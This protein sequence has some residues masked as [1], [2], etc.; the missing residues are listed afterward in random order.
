[1][2]KYF[3]AFFLVVAAKAVGQQTTTA[4]KIKE[5][6]NS[7]MQ[8][9]PVKGFAGWNILDRMKYYKVPGLSIAVISNYKVDWAKAYGMADTTLHTPVTTETM[10]SA[11]SISKLLMAVTALKLV[12]T[13]KI[14]LDSPINNY[15]TSWK[16]AGN[17]FTQKTPVTLRMLLSH[18][19]GTSQSSYFGFT[20]DK[21]PL[22]TIVQIL[23]GD[24]VAATRRVVV[25]SEPNKVF[26]YSGG[27]SMIA[28]MAL[29]DVS[30]Q[31]FD[32]LTKQ[33]LFDKLGMKHST[34]A[35]PVP[36]A[37]AGK[38]AWG[39]SAASWYKGMPYVYPQ[40]AAAGLYTTPTDLA[41]FFIDIQLSVLGKG[42]VL[43]KGMA[44]EMLTP[45]VD[46]SDGGYKEQMGVGPFLL[47]RTDNR[48]TAGIYFE[49]TGVNAG[50]LAYGIASIKGGNGVVVMLNSGD[51]Q[52]G[53]GKE[54]RR[55][56]AKTYHWVNYLPETIQPVTLSNEQLDKMAGRYRMGANEV[57]YLRRE[58]NYLVENINE[59]NDIYCFP[60]AADTI[61][62]TDFNVKGFFTFNNDGEAVS[63]QS[64]WQDKPMRK[65]KANEFTANEYLKMKNY[66]AAKKA[67]G[68]LHLNEYQLTYIAYDLLNKKP[69]D[70]EAAKTL[71][72]VTTEQHPNAGIVY[73]R[74]G[75]YYQKQH[76]TANAIKN[77]QQALKLDPNDTQAKEI[78]MTLMKQ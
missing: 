35:Q 76:D 14:S 63:L 65:M 72:D 66:T 36:A 8:Y 73:S 30:H 50:F 38:T 6:E 53:I 23:N 20:P 40:Q 10:F 43:G 47:Q 39:Y 61:V 21:N 77:Y 2:Y 74:W 15:L 57:L 62:F 42:N 37:F 29:M 16:L 7:L 33:V 44:N 54:I 32:A 75:E 25:N 41:K 18:K 9:V 48:D 26:Q 71:L 58:N 64:V 51:D 3:L 45:Q 24:P 11:G 56:V 70:F 52:N 78:L 1:M 31:S 69:A 60:V 49:F 27:G 17:A 67:F 55:A 13:G 68:E 34:F 28:Q 46:V 22:P 19:G 59:G 5:V 12:E 4:Q